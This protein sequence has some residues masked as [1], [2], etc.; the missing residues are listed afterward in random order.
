MPPKKRKRKASYARLDAFCVGGIAALHRLDY[1]PQE[2]VDS[3]SLYWKLCA[4]ACVILFKYPSLDLARCYIWGIR[5]ASGGTGGS[6]RVQHKQILGTQVRACASLL[7]RRT[8]SQSCGRRLPF[9]VVLEGR[10]L[11]FPNEKLFS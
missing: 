6:S 10:K 3:D 1:K 2:I 8:N 7:P 5:C 9:L 11:S 4:Y